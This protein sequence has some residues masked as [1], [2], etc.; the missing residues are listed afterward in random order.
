[1]RLTFKHH[2]GI[3][4]H[5]IRK[6]KQKQQNQD[7]WRYNQ[8]SKEECLE[9]TSDALT[10]S[11]TSVLRVYCIWCVSFNK[12]LPMFCKYHYKRQAAGSSKTSRLTTKQNCVT[13]QR[14]ITFQC[15]SL[16]LFLSQETTR[17]NVLVINFLRVISDEIAADDAD[18]LRI[19]VRTCRNSLW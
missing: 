8:D 6:Q 5:K 2:I 17:I 14:I 4:V 13:I 3:F 7:S 15:I 1:M 16:Q 18:V 10:L 9:Y 11:S 19:D 12:D